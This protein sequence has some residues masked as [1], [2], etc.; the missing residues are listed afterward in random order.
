MWATTLLSIGMGTVIDAIDFQF[1]MTQYFQRTDC[2]VPDGDG[3]LV[4]LPP[5]RFQ[6]HEMVNGKRVH[7]LWKCAKWL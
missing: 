4:L 1:D 6:R 2:K 3:F 5:P 7:V